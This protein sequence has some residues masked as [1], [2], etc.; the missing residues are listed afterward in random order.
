MNSLIIKSPEQFRKNIVKKFNHLLDDV[1]KCINIEKGI[2]N[3][4]IK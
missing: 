4:C 2:Y 1:N 3:S